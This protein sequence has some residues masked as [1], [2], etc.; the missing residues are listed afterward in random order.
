MAAE[1]VVT[2]ADLQAIIGAK[3]IELFKLRKEA[4]TL[5]MERDAQIRALKDECAR[6]KG[7]GGDAVMTS[8]M[9]ESTI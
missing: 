8:S 7:N 1:P 2:L 6:L 5:L 9:L 3:E 4:E